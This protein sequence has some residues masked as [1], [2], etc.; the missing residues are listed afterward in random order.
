M[1][2]SIFYSHRKP[3]K[4]L[5]YLLLL[6]TPSITIAE[7]VSLFNENG[8]L[9]GYNELKDI[10][11]PKG[12]YDINEKGK[13][14][15]TPLWSAVYHLGDK[16]HQLE[17]IRLLFTYNADP[18]IPDEDGDTPLY[19]AVRYLGDNK[20]QLRIIWL[21]LD[22]GADPNIPGKDGDT[23]LYFAVRHL[24]ADKHHQLEIIWLL[25]DKGANPNPL[26]KDGK[27][28]LCTAI[29]LNNLVAVE[30]LL[31]R[32]ADPH[33]PDKNGDTP[34]ACA[35]RYGDETIINL[36]KKGIA[37][38]DKKKRNH[39]ANAR[40]NKNGDFRPLNKDSASLAKQENSP[41][42]PKNREKKISC[43]GPERNQ[44]IKLMT[45]CS[46]PFLPLFWSFL[47]TKKSTL[48]A[49]SII[50]DK[51][52]K[53]KI[54][55]DRPSPLPSKHPSAPPSIMTHRQIGP[56]IACA[57]IFLAL[58][59]ASKALWIAPI[60][61]KVTPSKIAREPVSK[62]KPPEKERRDKGANS[63]P[64]PLSFSRTTAMLSTILLLGSTYLL[65]GGGGGGGRRKR[66]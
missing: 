55:V 52:E 15:M 43:V 57:M 56:F 30:L 46:L 66:I 26:E 14:G 29:E 17:I 18:N 27:S 49:P 64:S 7:K 22:K 61:K 47:K 32:G 44:R 10:L 28:P 35:E 65:W 4:A 11:S 23:P 8:S 16:T 63:S 21:L 12:N 13:N 9:K 54:S 39:R 50:Q 41:Y 58:W 38:W 45:V 42:T 36:L 19:S 33:I 59:I 3:L 2:T 24:K 20:R 37:E 25:L 60:D 1:L 6:I 40:K 51:E 53:H 48:P 34:L 62:T 31:N 5:P